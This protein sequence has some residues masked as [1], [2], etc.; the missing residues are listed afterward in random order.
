MRISLNEKEIQELLFIEV[1]NMYGE[2]KDLKILQFTRNG[3]VV[4]NE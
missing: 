1:V 2:Q 4:I 3:L